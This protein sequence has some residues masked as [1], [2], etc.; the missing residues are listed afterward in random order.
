M[1]CTVRM[2][3]ARSMPSVGP[4]G[5]ETCVATDEAYIPIAVTTLVPSTMTPFSLFLR[6][7]SRYR[8]Y[9]DADFPFDVQDR[10]RLLERGITKLY[11]ANS[12]LGSYKAYLRSQ[13]NDLLADES[14]PP[15]ERLGGMNEVVRNVLQ[16][17]FARGDADQIVNSAKELAEQ[18]VQAI[19]RMDAVATD[20]LSVM[21]HDYQTFTHS[22]NVTYLCV[23]LASALGIAVDDLE[24]IATGGL[25]HDLGKLQIPEHILNKNGRL[26]IAEFAEIQR[27]PTTGFD[28]LC[29]RTDLSWGQLMMVYQHHE[30]WA[31]GGYPVGSVGAE[32]HPW[33][34]ICTVADVFEALTANRPYRKGM[35]IAEALD[36]MG[37]RMKDKFEPE[38]LQCFQTA[39]QPK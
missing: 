12:N 15:R 17:D 11:V 19:C 5:M 7:G 38:L 16:D 4:V 26:D 18:T 25:L 22:A 10:D 27:H 21:H 20:L 23:L 39:I 34:R 6:D 1:V 2:V 13:L 32:I 29:Q 9:R 37:G 14:L 28:A 36:L 24:L 8:L 31:G 3:A 30:D 35:P 33:A